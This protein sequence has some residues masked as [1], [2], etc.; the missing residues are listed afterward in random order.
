MTI[1]D[2]KK[3][4]TI[5]DQKK[6]IVCIT[7]YLLLENL[8]YYLKIHR[9][10]WYLFPCFIFFGLFCHNKPTHN[11]RTPKTIRRTKASYNL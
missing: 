9:F 8:T 1:F 3:F 6:H 5:F 7:Y 2:Q 11:E 4:M 10:Y